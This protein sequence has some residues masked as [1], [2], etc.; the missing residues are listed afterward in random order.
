MLTFRQEEITKNYRKNYI[1]L[2]QIFILVNQIL[3]NTDI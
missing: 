3:L 1:I 2:L